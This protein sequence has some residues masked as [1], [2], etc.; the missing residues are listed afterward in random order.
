MT[1]EKSPAGSFSRLDRLKLLTDV[2]FAIAMTTMAL[3]IE[4]PPE[5]DYTNREI[6]EFLGGQVRTFIVVVISFILVAIYW[7]KNVEYFG[8]LGDTNQSHSWLQILY[9]AF[10]VLVPF[11]NQLTIGFPDTPAAPAIYL[12]NILLLGACGAAG[13]SYASKDRRLLRPDVST[14]EIAR[15]RTESKVEPVVAMIALASLSV[16][17]QAWEAC[18]LLIPV[19]FARR[20]RRRAVRAAA[21]SDR[22]SQD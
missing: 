4:I 10:L 9:L 14:A 17:P 7:F 19:A 15:I 8:H 20:V 13:W 12:A 21:P 1:N 16:H 18:L 6:L 11:T 22:A 3:A 2:I 5:G